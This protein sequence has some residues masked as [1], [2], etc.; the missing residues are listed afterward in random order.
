MYNRE[1]YIQQNIAAAVLFQKK[2]NTPIPKEA[3]ANT[4]TSTPISINYQ[5]K[6]NLD[7]KFLDIFATVE[8]PDFL[9][10]ASPVLILPDVPIEQ[11]S[12]WLEADAR[13]R[14]ADC[15]EVTR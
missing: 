13:R 4:N 9:A 10:P 2:S 3:I 12:Q 6:Y 5:Q 1:L 7:N 8:R 15:Q 14:P 11:L